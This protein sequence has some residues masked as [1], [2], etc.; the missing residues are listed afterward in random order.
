M[1]DG[2][3][4]VPPAVV[5]WKH[6]DARQYY[7][8]GFVTGMATRG[9]LYPTNLVK[10]RLQMQHGH[11]HYSGT[12]DA[13]KKIVRFEG[14]RALYKGFGPYTF[15]IVASQVYITT[16]ELTRTAAGQRTDSHVARDLIAGGGAS[17]IAQV[18]R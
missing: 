6:I 13:F 16:Y 11:A 9:V 2:D 7:A 15:G 5:E 18:W 4:T 14:V 17:L 10:T 8:W 1:S 12:V 3:A